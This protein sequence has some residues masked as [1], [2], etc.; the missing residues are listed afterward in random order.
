MSK[1]H[2]P[3]FEIKTPDLAHARDALKDVLSSVKKQEM[4][5]KT[6][7]TIV[8]AANGL[9]SAVAADLR[10]RLAAPRLAELEQ[11]AA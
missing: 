3:Q 7:N 9:R 1:P 11:A 10:V 8:S 2:I 4:D 6:A 5:N